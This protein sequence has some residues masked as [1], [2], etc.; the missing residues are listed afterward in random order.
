MFF[1][2]YLLLFATGALGYGMIEILWRGYTHWS[3]MLTGGFC[4]TVIYLYYKN[5]ASNLL[6][7]NCLVSTVIITATELLAGYILNIKMKL[8][9]WDYS[10]YPFNFMGQICLRYCAFWFM[11]SI[12]IIKLCEIMSEI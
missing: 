8:N 6:L 11:L 2:I 3:M 7:I 12:P 10:S 9:I 5:T 4:V 1:I